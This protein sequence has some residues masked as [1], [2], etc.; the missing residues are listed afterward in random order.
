M[1]SKN[2]QPIFPINQY[3]LAR[4]SN[5]DLPVVQVLAA[6]QQQT[7]P[8]QIQTA[9]QQPPYDY[10][11]IDPGLAIEEPKPRT[12]T[13]PLRPGV[14]YAGLTPSHHY[15]FLAWLANPSAAAPSAF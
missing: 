15:E 2:R 3:R 12:T 1:N 4:V 8:V 7:W 5:V 6:G 10:A 9:L 14:G 13:P 11:Q